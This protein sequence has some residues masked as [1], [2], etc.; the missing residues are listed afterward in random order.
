[1]I[2]VMYIFIGT[3][4]F[5]AFAS[6]F[7]SKYATAP[8]VS[9]NIPVSPVAIM[10]TADALQCPDGSFVG[11]TGPECAFV[12]PSAGVRTISELIVV[13]EP[14]ALSLVTSPLLITGQARGQWYFEGSFPVELQNS[15]GTVIAS[16]IA[17]T[18]ANWMT[19][20]FVPFTAHLQFSNPLVVGL[21]SSAK[22]GQ[23]VFK[24]DNPSGEPQNDAEFRVAVR[25]AP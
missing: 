14:A 5:A 8:S 4:L 11:R 21:D 24:K 1:M 19:T 20:D 7:L 9:E 25:F 13:T 18:S 2:K 15:N 22:M 17:T 23:L 16:G 12:C 3:A 10:C 6:I